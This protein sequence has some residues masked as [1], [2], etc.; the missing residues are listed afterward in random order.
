MEQTLE[1]LYEK[2]KHISYKGD[3][4]VDKVSL[5]FWEES[6]KFLLNEFYNGYQINDVNIVDI[7]LHPGSVCH[8]DSILEN[9]IFENVTELEFKSFYPNIIS[10]LSNL[11]T[12]KTSKE[13]DPYNEENWDED[14]IFSEKLI[15]NIN[16]F[17]KLFDFLLKNK[18]NIKKYKD[19]KVNNLLN[20]LINYT[21]G[22]INNRYS[23]F[24]K[25]NEQS[26]ITSTGR[27]ILTSL[28]SSYPN[29]IIYADTDTIYFSAF[30]EIENDVLDELKDIDIPYEIK[31]HL[32]LFPIRKRN[33]IIINNNDVI[34]RGCKTIK[35]L[36]E[37]KIRR[38]INIANNRK[39][40]QDLQK[41][42]SEHISMLE[43][44]TRF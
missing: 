36:R 25:C 39:R 10:K 1:N 11:Q 41:Q 38:E 20:I 40:I 23:N 9:K 16:E 13:N 31:N 34:F 5:K 19:E 22:A 12:N 37:Y 35:N 17:P 4:F 27:K 6:F 3:T 7:H 24:I 26:A 28:I 15:W 18:E 2:L 14:G 30:D 33:Y 44:K 42:K 43:Y 8:L 29:H 32:Y 21:Y